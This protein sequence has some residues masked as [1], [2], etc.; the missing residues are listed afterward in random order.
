MGHGVARAWGPHCQHVVGVPVSG[1]CGGGAGWN[2]RAVG[3]G[4]I[5]KFPC[6]LLD[7]RVSLSPLGARRRTSGTVASGTYPTCSGG[8]WSA[9]FLFSGLCGRGCLCV[10]VNRLY[11]SQ[12]YAS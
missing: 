6:A 2:L 4:S 11:A 9:Y 10:S 8:W 1:S 5:H 3:E 7:H 12:N